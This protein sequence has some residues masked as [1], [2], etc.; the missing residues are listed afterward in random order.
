[1]PPPHTWALGDGAGVDVEIFRN[2][3]AREECSKMT[4]RYED[5]TIGKILYLFTHEGNPPPGPG[6]ERHGFIEEWVACL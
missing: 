3:R 6:E 1:M 4:H 2:P 5:L